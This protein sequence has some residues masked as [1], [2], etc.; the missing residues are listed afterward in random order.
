MRL[1]EAQQRAI[2]TEAACVFGPHATVRLF[3]SRVD[4]AKQSGS[5][6]PPER[7]IIG[8]VRCA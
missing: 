7:S 3:G 1:T 2:V 6:D 8:W 4:D 5:T